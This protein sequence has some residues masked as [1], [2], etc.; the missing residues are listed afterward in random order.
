MKSIHNIVLLLFIGLVFQ[1][2]YKT[3]A[4]PDFTEQFYFEHDDATMAL[5]AEGTWKNDCMILLL[6]GGPGG[7]ASIYNTE[8]SSY[9]KSLEDEFAVVYWDQRGCGN[10]KGNFDKEDLTI[11]QYVDD[12]EALC[13]FLKQKYGADKK[14]VLMGHS[15]GGTLGSAFLIQEGLQDL[16]DGWI[17]VAGAHSFP[18]ILDSAI[19]RFIAEA[20][21]QIQLGNHET[22]WEVI[23]DYCLDLD[24][25]NL[26]KEESL[27]INK[28]GHLVESY[29]SDD[30]FLESPA[31]ILELLKYQFVSSSYVWATNYNAKAVGKNMI[32]ELLA[33]DYTD[34]LNKITI[35][36]LLLWGRYDFVVPLE[37]G[38]DAYN[39]ISS[40]A[41]E[42]II[43][44]QSGHSPMFN[45]PEQFSFSVINFIQSN[46]L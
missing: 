35:P 40:E 12:L 24:K 3:D 44:E 38:Q 42:L 11:Q 30:G 14:L 34:Q 18:R 13:I 23:R 16:V 33:A 46:I 26:T 5:W 22:D 31:D 10:S 2:C 6:H 20:N 43:F 17:E 4:E 39:E 36:S 45:E 32:D 15:W 19:D 9:E 41:K 1:S 8:I 28:N 25:N 29:L 7:V 37:L 27:E 21:T